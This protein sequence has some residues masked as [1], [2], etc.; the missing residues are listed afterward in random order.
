MLTTVVFM[1]FSIYTT[2]HEPGIVQIP[3]GNNTGSLPD[4]TSVHFPSPIHA[5]L[6][7]DPDQ[8]SSPYSSVNIARKIKVRP[9]KELFVLP[10]S[11]DD[12]SV[13]V[14]TDQCS[15]GRP[16]AG[17]FPVLRTHVAASNGRRNET[18]HAGTVLF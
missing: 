14:I 13:D 1:A 5:P 12:E 3:I 4:L 17:A 9:A 18:R 7:H 15:A 2:A 8:G 10:E 11:G 6:D 16:V